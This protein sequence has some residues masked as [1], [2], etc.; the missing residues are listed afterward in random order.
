MLE[1]TAGVANEFF[2]NRRNRGIF[3]RDDQEF[4]I[5]IKIVNRPLDNGSRQRNR[6][7]AEKTDAVRAFN[8]LKNQAHLR[9]R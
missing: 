6:I 5:Q 9:W 1:E 4:I 2:H 7:T 3:V 8:Q